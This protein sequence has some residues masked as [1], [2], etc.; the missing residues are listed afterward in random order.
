MKTDLYYQMVR[1]IVFAF[2]ILILSLGVVFTIQASLGV[3]PWDVLHIGL[4]IQT[5][6]AVGTWIIIVG[7][8]LITIT[9]IVERSL[10]QIGSLLNVLGIGFFINIIMDFQL[11]PSFETIW[12]R[13][14]E[15]L[16]GLVLLGFGS[17]MYVSAKLGAGPRDG[18]TLLLCHRLGWSVSRVR[19]AMEVIVVII[20]WSIGGP[21]AIGTLIT[22]V[23]I[24]PIMQ[25]SL[26]YWRKRMEDLAATRAKKLQVS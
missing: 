12:G 19:T 13:L 7:I 21:V 15:L 3:S 8:S 1:W 6:L 25:F 20:G 26:R 22:A 11:I 24:G 16:I 4:S 14:L 10:P 2:G 17:G 18:L 9:C 5:S 23:S